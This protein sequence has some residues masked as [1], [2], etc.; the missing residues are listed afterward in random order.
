MNLRNADLVRWHLTHGADPNIIT[1][2]GITALNFASCK[3]SLEVVKLLVQ[4]GADVRNTTAI[5]SAISNSIKVPPVAPGR[6]DIVTYLL[7]CGANINQLEPTADEYERPPTT[8]YTGTPLHRAVQSENPEH[9][10]YLLSRGADRSIRGALG[11]T[12]LEVAER[13]HLNDIAAM[14]REK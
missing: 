14:L 10:S 13:Y 12:P 1:R 9:V 11:M 4:H 5:H 7:E 3:F 8:P 6:L 2:R